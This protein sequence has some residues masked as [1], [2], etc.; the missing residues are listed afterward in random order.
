MVSAGDDKLA[1]KFKE[2]VS[3]EPLPPDSLRLADIVK[4]YQQENIP[5]KRKAEPLISATDAKKAKTSN[6]ILCEEEVPASKCLQPKPAHAITKPAAQ[7]KKSRREKDE[8]S[9]EEKKAPLGVKLVPMMLAASKKKES[10]SDGGNIDDGKIVNPERPVTAARTEESSFDD[11]SSFEEEKAKPAAKK[12]QVV[13]LKS[14][15]ESDDDSV[16]EEENPKKPSHQTIPTVVLESSSDSSDDE[17]ELAKTVGTTEPAVSTKE[18]IDTDAA[19]KVDI[20]KE[21]RPPMYIEETTQ[22]EDALGCRLFVHGVTQVHSR[23]DFN[24]GFDK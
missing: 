15:S 20:E 21:E 11:K 1:K 8:S 7:A 4:I 13:D 22:Q 10:N 6:N 2:E 9:D 19:K 16:V 14:S 17:E 24:S 18:E 3:P 5:R 12:V 23:L